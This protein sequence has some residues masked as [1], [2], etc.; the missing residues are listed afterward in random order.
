M[1]GLTV[2]LH[3]LLIS[4]YQPKG[5]RRKLL[6]EAKA[7]PSDRYAL[8]SQIRCTEAIPTPI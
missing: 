2:N 8:C 3:L 6:C 1:N 4:F 7:F 5:T